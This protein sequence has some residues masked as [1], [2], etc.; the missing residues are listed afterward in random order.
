MGN[1]PTAHFLCRVGS[2]VGYG[3]LMRSIALYEALVSDGWNCEFICDV[4]T[5]A[6]PIFEIQSINAIARTDFKHR[7]STGAAMGSE[8]TYDWL[9]VDDYA[10]TTQSIMDIRD[11]FDKVA[12]FKDMKCQSLDA[13]LIIGCDDNNV[14]ALEGPQYIPI[15]AQVVSIRDCV[16]KRHSKKIDRVSIFFG[17]VDSRGLT[18]DFTKHLLSLGNRWRVDVFIGSV[19]KQ[20]EE[21]THLAASHSEMSLFIDNANPIELMARSSFSIGAGGLNAWERCVVGLPSI[22]VSTST[23]QNTYVNELVNAGAAKMLNYEELSPSLIDDAIE[24]MKNKKLRDA[25][26]EAAFHLCDGLGA[27][28]ISRKLSSFCWG[29]S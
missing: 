13:D 24:I 7:Q 18:L 27:A 26:S 9:I 3:H 28:R 15:R 10:E 21:L 29:P 14:N 22:I 23:N 25:M 1:I 8:K 4:A 11:Y 20:K 2:E 12:V 5:L 6:Q 16:K 17:G 19:S